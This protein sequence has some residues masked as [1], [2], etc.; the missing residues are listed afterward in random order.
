MCFFQSNT[1]VYGCGAVENIYTKNQDCRREV[2]IH[3]RKHPRTCLR[4]HG[5]LCKDLREMDDVFKS[6]PASCRT[7]CTAFTQDTTHVDDTLPASRIREY[8]ESIRNQWRQEQGE[9]DRASTVAL[10]TPSLDG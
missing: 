3:S 4:M 10:R 2:C 7:E 5:V 6:D 9:R 8:V 1:T